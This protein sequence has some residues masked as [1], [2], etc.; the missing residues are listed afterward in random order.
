MKKMSDLPL[1]SGESYCCGCSECR[2]ILNSSANGLKKKK[3]G[4]RGEK[5]YPAD[6]YVYFPTSLKN[7]LLLL[8]SS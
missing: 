4:K 3:K 6:I 2:N 8:N 1:I 5:P 7:L